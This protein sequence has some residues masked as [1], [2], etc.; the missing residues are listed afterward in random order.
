M[1]GSVPHGVHNGSHLKAPTQR[2][3]SASI[4]MNHSHV[5]KFVMFLRY[6]VVGARVHEAPP[7][8]ARSQSS[9]VFRQ[10]SGVSGTPGAPP[11]S[12][13]YSGTPVASTP[14]P[15]VA[16]ATT[17]KGISQIQNTV[18]QGIYMGTVSESA[19]IMLGTPAFA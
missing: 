6:L 16:V 13:S 11:P 4:P 12:V 2:V 9:Q 3:G 8:M 17:T 19:N 5:A 10:V 1:G 7:Q 15:A 14:K 18:P